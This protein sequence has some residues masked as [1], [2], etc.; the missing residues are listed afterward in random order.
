M[1]PTTNTGFK[2]PKQ[3]IPVTNSANYN[4]FLLLSGKLVSLLGSSIYSFAIGLYILKITGSGTKF[5]LSLIIGIL[6]R[7]ILGPI[8]GALADRFDRKLMVVSTDVLSG[9]LMFVVYTMSLT[10]GPS[11]WMLY[12]SSFLLT[13]FNTFFTVA[14]DASIPNIVDN[15]KLVRINSLNQSIQSLSGILGPILGGLAYA[16]LDIKFFIIFNGI[17]FLL[18]AISEMFINFNLNKDAA[19]IGPSAKK[20]ILRDMAEGFAYLKEH[21]LIFRIIIYFLFI[22]LGFCG[23]SIFLPYIVVNVLKMSSGYLGAIQSSLAIGTLLVSLMISMLPQFK[24]QYKTMVIALMTMSVFIAA[25]GIPALPFFEA[26]SN[27][28]LLLY[29]VIVC[30]IIGSGSIMV[31]IPFRIT[32][33]KEISDEF[34][35]RVFGIIG[36]LSMAVMPLGMIAFGYLIDLVPGYAVALMSGVIGIIVVLFMM[37]DSSLK[38]I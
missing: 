11:V 34:R 23:I 33:Q 10:A 20:G 13:V 36:S 15:S 3:F 21:K 4:M 8:S 37:S 12:L 5:A 7:I 1:N 18:S 38:S 30:F 26:T 17:S 9:V 14:V 6:P 2:K 22:N 24:S 31:N 32:M 19:N 27:T 35:G 25:L 29:Y 16:L 28:L